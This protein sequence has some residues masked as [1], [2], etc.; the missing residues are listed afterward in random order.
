MFI[1]IEGID[2]V[3]KTSVALQIVDTVNRKGH[4]EF[5]RAIYTF[6]PGHGSEVGKDIRL[7]MK[8]YGPTASPETM[9]QLA[10]AA[11]HEQFR[12][13]HKYLVDPTILVVSDRYDLSTIAYQKASGLYDAP[14]K[15]RRRHFP[16]TSLPDC[17]YVIHGNERVHPDPDAFDNAEDEYKNRVRANFERQFVYYRYCKVLVNHISN[18]HRTIEDMATTILDTIGE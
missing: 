11:R 6:A 15:L 2:G 12:N 18:E 1:A 10:M 4:N 5:E 3:G 8:R 16:T 13:M 17:Y 9:F 7:L 14:G